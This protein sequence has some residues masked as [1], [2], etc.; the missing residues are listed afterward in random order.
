VGLQWEFHQRSHRLGRLLGND[1][2]W[3]FLGDDGLRRFLG[4]D[5]VWRLLGNDGVRRFLGF[6]GLWWF[7]RVYRL[8]RER[9]DGQ[10]RID[11]GQRRQPRNGRR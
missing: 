1:G 4:N 7:G 3:R 8:G 10:R 9:H 11:I 2:V 5:G 6:D